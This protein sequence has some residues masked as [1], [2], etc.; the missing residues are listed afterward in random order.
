M[1]LSGENRNLLG[2]SGGVSCVPKA[3]RAK[4]MRQDKNGSPGNHSFGHGTG[5]GKD[6]Q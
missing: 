4:G 1:G 6:L 2:R 3:P 5:L